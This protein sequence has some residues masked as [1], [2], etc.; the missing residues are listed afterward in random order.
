[1]HLKP[2]SAASVLRAPD[3]AS[4]PGAAPAARPPAVRIKSLRRLEDTVIRVGGIGESC[5]VNPNI[6]CT[7]YGKGLFNFP[8]SLFIAGDPNEFFR[9]ANLEFVAGNKEEAIAKLRRGGYVLVTPEFADARGA[10]TTAYLH[11]SGMLA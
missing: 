3:S 4:A 7:I 2:L 9:I 10:A 1:M 11:S 5:L 8:I 6:R